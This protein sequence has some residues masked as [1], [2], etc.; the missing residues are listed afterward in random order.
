M[1][2]FDEMCS[3]L[4]PLIKPIAQA[5]GPNCEVVLHDTR[6]LEHS[7]VAIENGHVT[8][9]KVGD[10]STNLGLEIM[11][12]HPPKEGNMLNYR[13]RTQ[14]GKVLKSSSIYLRN[15][16][17]EIMGSICINYDI[18]E[19][20]LVSHVLNDFIKTD[21][22]VDETFAG[23]INEVIENLLEEAI[24]MVGKP[25]PYMQKEDKM[26]VLRFLDQKGV[27]TVKRSMNRVA[28]FLGISK[29]TIYN[30]LEEARS[31]EENNQI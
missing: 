10:S 15:D 31:L 9:R 14:D 12:E 30:Y 16:D 5:L 28:T 21:Q 25:I 8:G 11:K 7:I 23:D 24:N 22:E 29:F 17:G 4:K 27:F 6:E 18:S 20:L 1:K 3:V 19:F 13:A 2:N 26:K